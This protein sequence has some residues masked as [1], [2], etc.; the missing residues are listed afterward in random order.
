VLVLAAAVLLA[1]GGLLALKAAA[2][3][4]VAAA[5]PVLEERLGPLDPAAY[6]LPPVPAEEN[7]FT[8][9][10]RGAAALPVPTLADTRVL[11]L[12]ANR[13]ASEWATAGRAALERVIESNRRG[14]E[15]LHRAAGLERSSQRVDYSRGFATEVPNYIPLLRAAKALAADARWALVEGDG[16]RATLSAAALA[17]L[18]RSLDREPTLLAK[19]L[20]S[21]AEK[22]LLLVA[23]TAVDTGADP[24]VLE[25]LRPLLG[26]SDT[27][28][29][30]RTALAYDAAAMHH[31]YLGEAKRERGPDPLGLEAL[32]IERL[33]AEV[34]DGYVELAEAPPAPFTA[35][36]AAIELSEDGHPEIGKLAVPDLLGLAAQLA[37]TAAGRQLAA[38]AL[39][40]RAAALTTG[41]YPETLSAD[42]AHPDPMAGARP[43]YRT[44]PDGSAELS[45]PEAQAAA[46]RWLGNPSPRILQAPLTWRLPPPQ[47]ATTPPA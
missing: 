6:N 10:D 8:W 22:K 5:W 29:G 4:R 12:L 15:I 36:A 45:L 33:Y 42:L 24:A 11:D 3:H 39:D 34:V 28:A 38:T 21:L 25:R 19:I 26:G 23:R 32:S 17:A 16:E 9:L 30:F 37:A 40:L 43:S 7:A 27:A 18:A 2:S 41:R 31:T 47:H 1:L 35:L 14:V 20:G 46:D 13:D 44:L